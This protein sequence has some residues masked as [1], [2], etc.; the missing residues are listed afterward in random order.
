MRIRFHAALSALFASAKPVPAVAPAPSREGPRLTPVP[1][2]RIPSP[3]EVPAWIAG[4]L[5]A[6]S[7]R[8]RAYW[9]PEMKAWWILYH[10]PTRAARETGR[11][12]LLRYERLRE[13]DVW[14][15]W[16]KQRLAWLMADGWAL[17]AS[18]PHPHLTAVDVLEVSRLWNVTWE[19]VEEAQAQITANT[20]GD[21]RRDD[22]KKAR[23]AYAEDR[24]RAISAVVDRGRVVMPPIKRTP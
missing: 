19:Q 5:C 11:D 21:A 2:I 23:H 15:N 17:L 6:I 7:P 10:E 16:G 9:Y 1:T 13:Q 22:M 12:R 3:R 18:F 24:G 8:L 14:P 4:L 20:T